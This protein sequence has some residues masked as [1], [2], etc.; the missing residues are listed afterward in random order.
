MDAPKRT[1]LFALH[2]KLG[3]RMTV[4]GGFE[5]PVSYGGIIGEHLAVRSAA[6][7]FDLSHMGEF[8][9]KGP[10]ALA[11]LECAFTNSAARLRDGQAQYTIMC[12]EDGGTIDDLIVYRRGAD[13]YLLCVNASN[14]A[15]DWEWITGLNRSAGAQLRDVSDETALVAVQGPKAVSILALL[16]DFPIGDVPRFAI[17]AGKV[18]GAAC[19]A[20][21]TGYTGED[22]FELFVAPG[23][24]SGVF[25]AILE[26][27]QRE[28]V[29][30]CGLGARDTLRLEAGL[31]LYGHE[32][33]RAT[34]PLE[35]GLNVFVKLERPFV[36]ESALRAQRDVGL[37]KRLIGLQSDD[38][39]SIARQGYKL[40][41]GGREAGV[42]TSGTLGPTIDRPIAMAYVA[43]GEI[44]PT[45][46]TV[47]E[48]LEVEIRSRRIPATIVKLPFYRRAQAGGNS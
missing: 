6:G 2:Q 26:T 27:G 24:A 43:A 21:R 39:R 20:A 9:V 22:G 45:A 3:A 48:A 46:A 37:R 10:Q 33:D 4:F 11:L 17:A 23:D 13:D 14:I 18:A 28:G 19:L 42:V 8:E 15:V 25:S 35:A 12:A 16:A 7:V 41:R 1:A 40:F 29:V 31:P 34:S 5:M 32:L 44:S 38:A 30:P 36:G 47:G